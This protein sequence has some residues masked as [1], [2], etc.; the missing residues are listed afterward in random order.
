MSNFVGLNTALTGIR[1]SQFALDTTANNVANA[2]TEGYT[3]QRVTLRPSLSYQSAAGPMGTGVTITGIGRMRDGFLDARVRT[4]LGQASF[5]GTQALLL[6]RTEAVMAEPDNGISSAL[7]KIFDAF[8]DLALAPQGSAQQRQVVASLQAL[9]G[10]IQ[11]VSTGWTQLENDTTSQLGTLTEEANRLLAQVH[12]LNEVIPIQTA[13]QGGAPNDLMDTRDAIADRLAELLGTT[14]RTDANGIME[15]SMGGVPLVGLVDGA[16]EVRQI[17]YDNDG[18][19]TVTDAED[20]IV[21]VELSV[22]GEVGGMAD[23]LSVKLPEQ[24]VA[25]DAF[26]A[27]LAAVLNDQHGAVPGA[28]PADLFVSSDA[29]PVRASSITVDAAF[30][31]DPSL[32]RVGHPDAGPFDASNII[33]LAAIRDKRFADGAGNELTLEQSHNSNVINL[34]AEVAKAGHNAKAEQ[35]LISAAMVARQGAHG[36]SL[37]EEMAALVQYQRSLEAMSRVMTTID[38]ALNVLIN[39][40]GIVGR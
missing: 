7:G 2:N 21:A 28:G 26:V 29:G 13:V 32:L 19:F 38:E 30:V 27:Q 14:A 24:R 18:G 34:G 9:A 3:R 31:A 23:Y 8:E 5:H 10:R 40:T 4:G 20:V 16:Q 1:A 11:S 6:A 25:L 22:S 17:T 35:D 12:E 15:I 33:E 36:V 39:R 37:D